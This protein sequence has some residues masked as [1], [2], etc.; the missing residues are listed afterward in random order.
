MKMKDEYE[1]ITVIEGI[2]KEIRIDGQRYSLT[3]TVE[4]P[5]FRL[6]QKV[7]RR[8]H[9]VKPDNAVGRDKVYETWI[10]QPEIDAVKRAINTVELNY[11]PTTDNIMRKTGFTIQRTRATLHWMKTVGIITCKRE[12]HRQSVHR[13]ADNIPSISDNVPINSR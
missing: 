12:K 8:Y 6:P 1:V 4:Q 10:L 9:T 2:L 13:L 3:K 5:I 7:H 11:V